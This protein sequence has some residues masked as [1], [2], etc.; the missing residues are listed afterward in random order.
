MT[1]RQSS[2]RNRPPLEQKLP[3]NSL[4]LVVSQTSYAVEE[5]EQDADNDPN[6]NK[7]HHRKDDP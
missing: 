2:P 7:N 6:S 4:K 1:Q 5:I 3:E